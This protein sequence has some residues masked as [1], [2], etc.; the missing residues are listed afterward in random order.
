M[1]E[2]EI[3]DFWQ[4][5]P[6]GEDFVGG[7]ENY[8]ADYETFFENYDKFRYRKESHILECL[9]AI[10]FHGKRTLEIGLGQ[11]ADSEQV[12]N[13]GADWFGLDLTGESTKRVQLRLNLRALKFGGIINGSAVEMP[14]ADKSF[15]IVF[16]HGV[17]HHIPEIKTAQSEI[18]RVLK[19]DGALIVMLYA[20]NSLNYKLS[21]AVVRRLGLLGMYLTKQG[22]NGLIGQHLA[23]ARQKGLWNYLKMKNFIHRNT[24]GALNPYSKVYDLKEIGKD[25]PDFKIVKSYKRFMHAPPLPVGKLPFENFLGWHL[26]AHLKPR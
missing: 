11:G 14:F 24:D 8:K 13:R 4:N 5:H 20:K 3:Q 7:A 12:I 15:D 26:W 17:L 16:S 1:N 10:D 21:I 9:N 23:N 18:H 19:P 6:C 2:S 25:F 22:A